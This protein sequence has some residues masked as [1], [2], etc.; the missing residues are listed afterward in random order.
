M[1]ELN[2]ETLP[3]AIEPAAPA[4]ATPDTV[5]EVVR[6]F[7]IVRWD[8]FRRTWESVGKFRNTE[9]ALRQAMVDMRW[10]SDRH[11]KQLYR[12]HALVSHAPSRQFTETEDI[13]AAEAATTE[14]SGQLDSTD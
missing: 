5:T 3:P 6:G 12:I 11:P 10:L 1:N 13:P 9:L 8:G 2:E 4:E 7:E 14:T